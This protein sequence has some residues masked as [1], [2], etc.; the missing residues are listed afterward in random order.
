MFYCTVSDIT[1]LTNWIF[2]TQIS[3]YIAVRYITKFTI[4]VQRWQKWRKETKALKTRGRN[5]ILL[6][7]FCHWLYLMMSCQNKPTAT[8]KVMI[9][10]IFIFMHSREL[11]IVKYGPKGTEEKQL[12]SV[13]IWNNL[14]GSFDYAY[15]YEFW[16]KCRTVAMRV[17]I[18]ARSL[19]SRSAPVAELGVIVLFSKSLFYFQI[20][21]SFSGNFD[22]TALWVEWMNHE[23]VN[24]YATFLVF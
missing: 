20:H 3:L 10:T 16:A 6:I 23:F 11:F 9:S 12:S 17:N 24:L 4:P 14:A 19:F 13:S 15:R 22:S 5:I 2:K 8:T 1:R 7:N 18:G 21:I